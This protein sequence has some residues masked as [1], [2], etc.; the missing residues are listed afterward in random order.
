[1]YAE[2]W[3]PALY[4][5]CAA[6][7]KSQHLSEPPQQLHCEHRDKDGTPSRVVVK[8]KAGLRG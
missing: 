8:A 7:A 2:S 1:M 3:V 6:S 5:G 4:S